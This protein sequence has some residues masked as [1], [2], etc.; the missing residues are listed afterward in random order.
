MGLDLI[1]QEL[2]IARFRSGADLLVG[3]P[4][5]DPRHHIVG[6]QKLL[7][8]LD[9][10]AGADRGEQ[11]GALGFGILQR[12][13]DA[14]GLR[15]ALAVGSGLELDPDFEAMRAAAPDAAF[16]LFLFCHHTCSCLRLKTIS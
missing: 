3:T 2:E 11:L 8:L 5:R 14:D 9:E 1:A 4:L 16:H 13:F 10:G 7:V 15:P 6:D 12:A